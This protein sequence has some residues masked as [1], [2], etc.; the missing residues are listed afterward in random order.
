MSEIIIGP[1]SRVV[2]GPRNLDEPVSSLDGRL[3]E[4]VLK[5]A[6]T[7]LVVDRQLI[8]GRIITLRVVGKVRSSPAMKSRSTGSGSREVRAHEL[9]DD[10]NRSVLRRGIFAPIASMLTN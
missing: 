10:V 1:V 2:D 6:C 4:P 3:N 7:R 9:S 5:A 8:S